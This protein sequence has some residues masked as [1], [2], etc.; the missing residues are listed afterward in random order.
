MAGEG[1]SSPLPVGDGG[2]G[3]QRT[4]TPCDHLVRLAFQARPLPP[5]SFFKLAPAPTSARISVEPGLL[6]L[7]LRMVNLQMT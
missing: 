5:L 1:W 4:V 6:N 3:I 7:F 2:P